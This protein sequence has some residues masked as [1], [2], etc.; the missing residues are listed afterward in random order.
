M[1]IYNYLEAEANDICNYLTQDLDKNMLTKLLKSPTKEI[2]EK[3]HDEIKNDDTITGSASGSY[4]FDKLKA[5]RFLF[6]NW[7]LLKESIEELNVFDNIIEL[8]P[9]WADVAI[10]V[11]LFDQAFDRAIIKLQEPK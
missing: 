10:R 2:Q 9:E 1:K 7:N 11:Y 4:A 6:G 8:G 3:V 5:E